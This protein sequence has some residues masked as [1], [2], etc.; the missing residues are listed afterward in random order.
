VT[1]LETTNPKNNELDKNELRRLPAYNTFLKKHSVSSLEQ[2]ALQSF[3]EPVWSSPVI[4]PPKPKDADTLR[5]E[6]L[7][8]NEKRR[9]D[10]QE[11]RS[12]LTRVEGTQGQEGPADSRAEENGQTG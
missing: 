4:T 2:A 10:F 6:I 12:W 5:R 8:M 1:L 7:E 9:K 11:V 3:P